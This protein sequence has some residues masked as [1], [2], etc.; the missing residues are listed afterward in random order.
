MSEKQLDRSQVA[1]LAVDLRR[2][3]ATQRVRAKGAAFHP[4]SLDP[5]MHDA[6][7]LARRKVRLVVDPARENVRASILR[8]YVQ[9]LLQRGAG[10]LHDLE[11]NR[12]AR[13]ILL[14]LSP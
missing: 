14:G 3:G 4:R 13:L 11:L 6:R 10:L 12:P 5:A 7:V 1:G 9:P 8:S 2:L